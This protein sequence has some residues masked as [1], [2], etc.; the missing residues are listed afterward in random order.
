MIDTAVVLEEWGVIDA[1]PRAY[2]T[3][4]GEGNAPTDYM[5]FN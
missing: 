5:E 4:S 3:I 1:T 2:W